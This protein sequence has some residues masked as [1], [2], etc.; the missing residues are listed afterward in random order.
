[1]SQSRAEENIYLIT[2]FRDN[3]CLETLKSKM[4]FNGVF[5]RNLNI[6][7][8][9]RIEDNVLYIYNEVRFYLY[10]N[11]LFFRFLDSRYKEKVDA[12]VKL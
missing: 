9:T 8:A 2:V 12:N 11:L 6:Y 7:Y 10:N 4:C 1:M 5:R 3:I